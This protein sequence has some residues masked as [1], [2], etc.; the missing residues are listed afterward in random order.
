MKKLEELFKLYIEGK[1]D[2]FLFEYKN[3]ILDRFPIVLE[4]YFNLKE[5]DAVKIKT[6]S[7]EGDFK[8][9]INYDEFVIDR[10]LDKVKNFLHFDDVIEMTD[11]KIIENFYINSNSFSD[12]E[13]K[14]CL[15]DV[16]NAPLTN[17]IPNFFELYNKFR[18]IRYYAIEL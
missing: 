3:Y 13:I 4:K 7:F 16:Y 18:E 6:I 17:L 14:F 9:N 8:I 10:I 2:Y 1:T 15:R 5:G 11:L 12:G